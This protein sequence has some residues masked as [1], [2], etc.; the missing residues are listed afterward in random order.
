[1]FHKLS[2]EKHSNYKML[3]KH[4]KCWFCKME[5]AKTYATMFWR[6]DQTASEAEKAYVAEGLSEM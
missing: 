3:I 2:Y 1:M 6:W 5:S 4:L